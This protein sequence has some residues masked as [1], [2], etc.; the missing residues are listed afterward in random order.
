MTTAHRDALEEEA[1]AMGRDL[2]AYP[3]FR[4]LNAATMD[5]FGA[6]DERLMKRL[7]D[8]AVSE[9]RAYMDEYGI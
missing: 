8:A 3:L 9:R 7:C 6:G 4:D 5:R 1:R 2:K